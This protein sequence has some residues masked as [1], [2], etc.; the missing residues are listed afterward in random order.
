MMDRSFVRAGF[1]MASLACFV[2]AA[3]RESDRRGW[4]AFGGGADNI[5]YSSLTQINRG[6]AAKLRVAWQYDTGDEF[7]G[8]EMECNPIV[9]GG[10]LF[11]TT[12]KLRVI[13]LDA[14]TGTLKWSFDP[15]K[16]EQPPG[17]MRNR[18]VAYWSGGSEGDGRI[19]VASREFMYALSAATGKPVAGFGEDGRIDLRQNLGRDPGS[20][21]ISDT[22]P[23][24]VYKDLLIVGSIVSEALPAL[25]GDIRAY[26]VKSGKLRWSF[27]TLPHPG[28]FGYK[29]WPSD[30]WQYIGG[31]NNWSGMS[32][33][34]ERGI[35]FVPTGSASFDFYGANRLGDNLFANCLIALNAKT[36]ERIWHFQTVHHDLWDRDLPAAPALVTV[37]RNGKRVD[38]VAQTTK[39]G[40]VFLFDRTTG[41]PLFPITERPYPASDVAGEKTA[42]TQ[43]LPEQPPPFARQRLT[44]DMLTRR[45]EA[46]HADVLA[47]FR[48]LR[49]NGQFVPPSFAGTVIFPGFDGGAEWGGPAFDPESGLLYVNANEMAWVLRLVERN[50]LGRTSTGKQLYLRNC[51]GCHREDMAGTPPE[52]PSLQHI[53]DRRSEADV[54]KMIRQGGGRMPAFSRLGTEEITAITK[55]VVNGENI[56]VTSR[57]SAPSKADLKYGI[58]GYNKFLDPDGYPAVAPPWGTLTAIDLNAGTLKWQI[59]FGEYPELAAQGLRNTGSENYGGPV[60]TAG[61]VIFIAATN[62]DKKFHVFDKSTGKL[63]WETTLPAAGNATPAVYE[64]NGRE[65]IAIA[66]GG[67]KSKAAPGGSYVAFALGE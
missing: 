11:A 17:K 14:A 8:S 32:V 61:G 28:E 23:P 6:N 20:L 41:K 16:G 47:R 48:K 58:D 21:M 67:G 42:A 25:P 22:S 51:A 50:K 59:P 49:S 37:N 7:K 40:F 1:A 64:V 19:F 57:P 53:T 39:S 3:P 5:H 66:C 4:S 30:A 29:T 12:P 55:F 18:G 45:T 63:L 34:L 52:F 13:A 65:Y 38:A 43:P 9:V 36:G 54:T 46:A 27:H 35:V 60:V 62:Y 56:S 10:V 31:V 24:V 33:D 44:E 2:A 15:N 26:D